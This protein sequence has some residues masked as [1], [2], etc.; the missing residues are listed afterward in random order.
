MKLL[1]TSD[2]HLGI[3]MRGASNYNQDQKYIIGEI[4]KI[5]SS[6]SVDGII[7][8][9]DV[10]DKNVASL[11]AI[12]LYDEV[13]T[14]IS[15]SLNIPVFIIAGNHDGSDRL[16]QLNRLLVNSGVYIAG[17][18]ERE[19]K[20]YNF[21]DTDIYMLPWI[22]TDRV[23]TIYPEDA[24]KIESLEDAYRVVL[25]KIRD[26]FSPSHKKV[27]VS[28]SF[29][30]N[31]SDSDSV[32]GNAALINAS[33][34]DGF[35]YV[36]LG[37]IHK[38]HNVTENVRYSGAPMAYSF[39]TEESQNKSVTIYDTNDGSKKE[40]ILKPI[41]ERHTIKDTLENILKAD[42][43]EN[44]LK[45]YVRLEVTDQFVG[46][47]TA[48]NFKLKYENVL[49]YTCPNIESDSGKITMSIEDLELVKGDPEKVFKSYCSDILDNIELS[50]SFLSMFKEAVEEYGKETE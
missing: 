16:S 34:Y 9:G 50:D 43:P 25:D 22:S 26:T 21:G 28:H 39:G 2:W 20:M 7:I 13:I 40:V 3:T 49:E 45:G 10:F 48:S 47:E 24:E 29:T 5:A 42:Y 14:D 33:V 18:L 46:F 36:A 4:C 27:L 44:I 37:H 38:P 19:P 12:R 35:D 23:K 41:R 6:E 1:H 17:S 31:G 8:A 30:V 11:E 15:S 32:V